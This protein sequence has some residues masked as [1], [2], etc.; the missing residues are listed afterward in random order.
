MGRPLLFG[1]AIRAAAWSGGSSRSLQIYPSS[2]A[3]ADDPCREGSIGIEGLDPVAMIAARRI[4]HG[5]GGLHTQA[6]TEI[7]GP[8]SD[9]DAPGIRAPGRR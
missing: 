9:S 1:R 6:M 4:V 3:N 7:N 2:S 8:E 5:M